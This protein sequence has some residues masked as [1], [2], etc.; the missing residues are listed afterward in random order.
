[1]VKQTYEFVS[2]GEEVKAQ[3]NTQTTPIANI[4]IDNIFEE[5]DEGERA[6]LAFGFEV[7]YNQA[8]E[9]IASKWRCSPS[10]YKDH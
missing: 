3:Q 9:D 6:I 2:A 7:G 5:F 4:R 8:L 10:K 1:M